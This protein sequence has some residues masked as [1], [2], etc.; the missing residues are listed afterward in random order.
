MVSVKRRLARFNRVVANRVI[1]QVISRMPGFGAVYHRGRKSGRPY[2]TPVKVFR[3]GDRF[4][5]SLPYG[6]DSDWVK[7]VVAA[8][9]C[10]LLTRWRRVRVVDPKVYVDTVQADIPRPLA[11]AL[12]K[13]K[14]YD[15]IELHVAEAA[16]RKP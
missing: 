7:N 2:R 16:A 13:I 11:A 14:A 4:I 3:A 8:G 1:G 15:F 12:K 6:P 5:L 10:E 9:E